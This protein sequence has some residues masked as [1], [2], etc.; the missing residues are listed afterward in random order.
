MARVAIGLPEHDGADYIKRPPTCIIQPV[1]SRGRHD[2]H[3]GSPAVETI[4]SET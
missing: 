2:D 4:R 1:Q 3:D